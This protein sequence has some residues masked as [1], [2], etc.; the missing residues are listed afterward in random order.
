MN[1]P[2]KQWVNE[3]VQTL[4]SKQAGPHKGPGA[5]RLD[6]GELPYPPSPH[7]QQAIARA[8]STLNRY[9][10]GLGGALRG[11][12]ADY[13]GARE[14]Q[15]VIGNGSDDLIELVV[16]TFV[17]PIEE[18][19][20][21]I[22]TFFVFWSATRTLGG[23]PVFVNRT[24]D[25]NLNVPAILDKITP[26]TKV[27][28]IA[29]PNNPTANLIPRDV[30]R[31]VLE[32]LDCIVV[33]DECYYEFCRQTAADLI[34][35]YPN[36]I[37]LRSL[38]KSFGLAG[39]RIGYAIAN[40]ETA[41]YLYR[42]AQLLPVNSLAMVG[43]IAAL[44][45]KSYAYENVERICKARTNLA[46]E[47]TAL[48]FQVYPSATNFLFIG[49]QSL[50][51]PSTSLVSALRTRNIFVQDFGLKPGLEQFYFRTSVGTAEENRALLT[52]LKEEIPHLAH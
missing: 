23:V 17:K 24:A 29:N 22:P 3:Y 25:F 42:A 16:K 26:K 44:G 37:I 8:S 48:G 14:E 5:I 30:I 20:I 36:L 18:V 13:T 6:M 46:H 27:L 52:I 4:E 43:A 40:E 35:Q 32:Q 28:F 51:I 9:P 38:S 39:L 1:S 7:V 41:D 19:L 49:T 34:E 21:P 47:L 33:V 31:S 11:V 45:D 12:L 2:I 15:I 10:E 50:G